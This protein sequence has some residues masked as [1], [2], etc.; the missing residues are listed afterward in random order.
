MWKGSNV[1]I[2]FHLVQKKLPGLGAVLLFVAGIS[3]TFHDIH[4]LFIAMGYRRLGYLIKFETFNTTRYK[5]VLPM[6]TKLSTGSS[7]KCRKN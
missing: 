3:A 7:I 2:F 4:G 6:Y 5:Y 1:M